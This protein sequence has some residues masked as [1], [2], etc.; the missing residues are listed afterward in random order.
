M[1]QRASQDPKWRDHP[2]Q[3]SA[4]VSSLWEP[5]DKLIKVQLL[6]V[7]SK[8]SSETQIMSEQLRQ[9]RLYFSFMSAEIF[10]FVY[11]VVFISARVAEDEMGRDRHQIPDQTIQR[12]A[13][14]HPHCQHRHS[15]HWGQLHSFNSNL[16]WYLYTS[17]KNLCFSAHSTKPVR[18]G[19]W[20]E[21]LCLRSPCWLTVKPWRRPVTTAK[22]RNWCFMQISSFCPN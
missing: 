6:Y 15:I 22:V 19:Q 2:V 17:C 11:G 12:L 13:A 4:I 7:V 1:P 10:Q 14:S 18:R 3:R 16:K 8:E 21:L 20:W 5:L 9:I